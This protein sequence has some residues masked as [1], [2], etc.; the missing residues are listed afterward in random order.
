LEEERDLFPAV[1]ASAQPGEE[2]EH[3]LAMVQRLTDE[4][5]AIE[6]L[7]KGLE[8][9]LKQVAKGHDTELDVMDLHELVGRYQAHAAYEEQAFLPLSER[10]LSRNPNHMAALGVSLHIRHARPIV[11]AYV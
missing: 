4:H 10:I 6:K 2:R 3:V 9:G 1:V 11:P 8:R 5:R 7:W